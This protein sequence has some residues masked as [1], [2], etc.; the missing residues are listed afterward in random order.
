MD[1]KQF[2]A[3]IAEWGKGRTFGSV[4]QILGGIEAEAKKHVSEGCI[5][6]FASVSDA[7][8]GYFFVVGDGSPFC[9]LRVYTSGKKKLSIVK[10]QQP[11]LLK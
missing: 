9:Y 11:R 6:R 8:K 4:E 5:A 2:T 1:A 3:H 7:G 10:V